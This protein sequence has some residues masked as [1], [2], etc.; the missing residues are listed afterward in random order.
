VS[1]GSSSSPKEV[2]GL[3]E[4]ILKSDVSV[5]NALVDPPDGKQW[6]CGMGEGQALFVRECYAWFYE[7]A[8]KHLGR[9][10]PGIIYTGNP[11]IGKS[12]WLS[13][14]LVRFLKDGYA[15]VLERAK[16][17]D[18]FVFRDGRC[19]KRKHR[20]PNLDNLPEKSVYLF[21]PDE[22]DSHPLE[23]NVF[24]IVASSPQ[25]KHYK[26]LRKKDGFEHHNTSMRYFPCWSLEELQAAAPHMDKTLLEERW[27]QWGGVPRYIFSDD[28]AVLLRKLNGFVQKLQLSLMEAYRGFP[29]IPEE[30]QKKLS[31]MVMQYRVVCDGDAP[32][33]HGQLDFASEI[34]GQ[35]VVEAAAKQDYAKLIAHY[36][37]TRREKWQGA[38]CGHLWEHLCHIIIPR[39]STKGLLLE[40][41]TTKR[42]GRNRRILKS[43]VNIEPGTLGNVGSILQKGCYFRPVAANF[44]VIDGAL[45]E[46][47]DV[48]G[49][50]MTVASSHPLKAHEASELLNALPEGKR[51][52]LVWVVDGAKEDRIKT[53]QPFVQSKVAAEKVDKR[54]IQKLQEVPQWLL[55]LPFPKESPFTSK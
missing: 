43:A 54:T 16:T 19:K 47:N 32:Y 7:E 34:I 10:S 3:Y 9:R 31:H 37:A 27:L 46:G 41:L 51:L 40:P 38:Y 23:S 28:Q 39:G 12:A 2:R 11:G 14:A 45:M 22:N 33:A 21:D 44:P 50:Q 17:S 26:A 52:H 30:Y 49:L 4:L 1:G 8:L 15:V 53:A 48:Y 20:R 18:Y 35:R 6:L 55:K 5:A 25:E 42:N 24:T 36:E 13:Y 29:E